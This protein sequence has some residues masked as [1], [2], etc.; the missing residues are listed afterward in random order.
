MLW[1]DKTDLFSASLEIQKPFLAGVNTELI[2]KKQPKNTLTSSTYNVTDSENSCKST[3]I[4]L[5]K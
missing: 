2:H 3:H 4:Q 1:E 5:E